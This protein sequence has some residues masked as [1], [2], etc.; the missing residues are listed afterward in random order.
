MGMQGQRFQ[1]Q[2]YSIN[3]LHDLMSSHLLLYAINK[4]IGEH[5]VNSL[6]FSTF[7]GYI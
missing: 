4:M 7:D 1:T 3:Q 2:L 6:S 5:S